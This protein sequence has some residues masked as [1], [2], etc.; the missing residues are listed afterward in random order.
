VTLIDRHI[1]TRFFAN[2]MVLLALL[3]VFAASI[4]VILNLDKFVD[5]SRAQLGGD[6]GM[7]RQVLGVV[8]L[9]ANFEGPRIF[10][11]YAYLHGLVAIG[12]MGF[13]LAHMHR[14]RE[15]VAVMASGV[16]LY[17]VAMPFVIAVFALSLVQMVN[18]EAILPRIAPLLLRD[19][20]QIGRHGVNEFEV[21]FTSD[22]RGNLLQ[23]PSFN[24]LTSELTW[25]TFLE[26]DDRGRTTR[27]IAAI[28]AVW[29]AARGGWSLTGARV[30]MLRTAATASAESAHGAQTID[31]LASDISPRVLIARRYGQ[32]SAML[33][34]D[35]IREMLQTPG[36]TDS[37]ALKRH[38]YARFSAVL[39]NLLVLLISLPSFLLREPANLMVHSLTCASMS[40]PAMIGAAI[41]M[42]A[43]LP[44]VSPAV[45]VFM[46]VLVLIP[47][48]MARMSF[49]KT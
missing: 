8:V 31:F 44:G 12:A 22:G 11:F 10:Q 41:G 46:P 16:S 23:A 43:Q 1:L 47:I 38:L 33:S 34:M 45:S 18:Q 17:R 36:V 26:R 35:Q 29:D 32:F 49:I 25:P 19:H 37:A 4:D 20:G 24:P 14:H 27:R 9:I 39:V 21:R 7:M 5:V 2:F 6:A 42:M 30:M 15:L 48:A 28:E 13:T 40:I 3:F